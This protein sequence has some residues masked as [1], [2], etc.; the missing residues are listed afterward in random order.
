M[1]K[2]EGRQFLK[3]LQNEIFYTKFRLK[4]VLLKSGYT[5]V[6]IFISSYVYPFKKITKLEC[7]FGRWGLGFLKIAIVK[8]DKSKN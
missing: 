5:N 7:L 2:K 6:K 4:S 3:E 1:I 8:L